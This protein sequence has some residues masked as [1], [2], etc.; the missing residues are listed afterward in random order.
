MIA[1]TNTPICG[2]PS[3]HRGRRKYAE[4]RCQDC[5]RYRRVTRIKFWV[6][7]YEML[8]CTDCIKPYRRVILK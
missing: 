2:C 5:G 6:N 1:K 8:V 7:G 3:H 4:G